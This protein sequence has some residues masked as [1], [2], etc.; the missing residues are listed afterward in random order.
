MIHPQ[1]SSQ[2]FATWLMDI[3]TDVLHALG[4]QASDGAMRWIYLLVIVAIAFLSGWLIQRLILVVVNKIIDVRFGGVS[5]SLKESRLLQ[6]CGQLMPAIVLFSLI[7]FAFD[8]D[9][10]DTHVILLV[11]V[12]YTIVTG[13]IAFNALLTFVWI[14][15]NTR[16]NDKNL[17][18]KGIVDI[19]KGAM[20]VVAVIVIVALIVHKSPWALL[21]GLGAFAAVLL[22]IFKDSILGLVAGVQLSVNDMLRVGDWISVPGTDAN[23]IVQ[24]VSLVVVK[25]KN[26]NNT[27]SM[28]P[29]YSLVSSHFVNW[30]YMKAGGSRQIETSVIVDVATV[31]PLSDQEMQDIAT[32]LPLLKN[33]LTVKIQQRDAGHTANV[34]N[35]DAGADGTIDTNLGLLRAYLN[36][37][38]PRHPY[39]MADRLCMVRLLQPTGEG[40]PLQVF[41]YTS[42]SDWKAYEAIQ[43]DIFEHVAAVAPVFGLSLYTA[44]TARSIYNISPSTPQPAPYN[45]AAK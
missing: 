41:C 2:H 28:L 36:L 5:Q 38:L 22:L 8:T 31:R 33:F 6:R 42:T 43:A 11:T 12:I 9:H 7:P 24:D 17:P 35:K 4:L 13:V 19:A 10:P 25:V 21:T 37:Y 34:F 23:G 45:G 26:W 32:R 29:P 1:L 16:L 3:I 15:Y 44:P 20:W 39:I 40:Y 30:R 27:V 14:R 18:L